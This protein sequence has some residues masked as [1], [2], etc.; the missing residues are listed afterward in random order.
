[1]SVEFV[2]PRLVGNAFGNNGEQVDLENYYRPG[3]PL[4][5]ETNTSFEQGLVRKFFGIEQTAGPIEILSLNHSYEAVNLVKTLAQAKAEAALNDLEKERGTCFIG[6]DTIVMIPGDDN[7]LLFKPQSLDSAKQ[8]INIVLEAGKVIVYSGVALASRSQVHPEQIMIESTAEF[9]EIRL[10]SSVDDVDR[11][12]EQRQDKIYRICGAIDYTEEPNPFRA[13]QLDETQLNILRGLPS[14]VI[15]KS[16][17]MEIVA[18]ETRFH[19]TRP[20]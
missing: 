19:Q 15:V 18:K 2:G 5:V 17:R 20:D 10:K 7:L 11:Y 1:M 8:M 4:L 3:K 16:L 13:N 6:R 9:V 12:L 14:P